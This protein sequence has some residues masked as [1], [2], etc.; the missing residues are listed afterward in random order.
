MFL[1]LNIKSNKSGIKIIVNPI[2]YPEKNVREA[3]K[4]YNKICKFEI[5]KM[6]NK[7]E[8]EIIPKSKKY[9]IEIV[10]FEFMNYVLGLSKTG[11]F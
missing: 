11:E 10:L 3:C 2:F 5:E 6:N 1:M 7:L 8:I 4:D 9:D